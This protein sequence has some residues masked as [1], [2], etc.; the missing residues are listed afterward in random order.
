M[1]ELPARQ[2]VL[3][4]SAPGHLPRSYLSARPVTLLR[5]WRLYARFYVPPLYLCA[6]VLI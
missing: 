2:A 5:W 6:E 1:V 3:R 4:S